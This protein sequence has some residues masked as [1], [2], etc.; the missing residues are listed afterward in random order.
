MPEP[1]LRGIT[2][3]KLASFLPSLEL[4][5]AFERL[6]EQAMI[7]TPD[8]ITRINTEI[9]ATQLGVFAPKPTQPMAVRAGDGLTLERDAA[10]VTISA[11]LAQI[12]TAVSAF[13]P[14]V[15]PSHIQDP[16]D[17]NTV[18]AGRVFGR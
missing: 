9:L 6:N 10:G 3:D 15:S 14:R 8:E 5:K 11:D 7:L 12:I 17:E 2:R 13:L 16:A 18:I 4:I 1:T